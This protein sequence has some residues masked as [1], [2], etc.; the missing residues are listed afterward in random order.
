MYRIV[1]KRKRFYPQRKWFG[2][3]WITLTANY[4]FKIDVPSKELAEQA[5]V[6]DK[7]YRE[8]GRIIHKS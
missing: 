2:L 1:E 7:G 5:I 8:R 6:D 4:G 3:F